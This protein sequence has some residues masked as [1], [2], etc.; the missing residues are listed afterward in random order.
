MEDDQFKADLAEMI[1]QTD[2]KHDEFSKLD[3]A[4]KSAKKSWEAMVEQVL[5]MGRRS[6]EE[7]P[8]FDGKAEVNASFVPDGEVIDADYSLRQIAGPP[9]GTC[10]DEHLADA[11]QDESWRAIEV[12]ELVRH[13]L[14]DKL[15]TK[16]FDAGM[17]TMGSLANWSSSGKQLTDLPGI[18]DSKAAEI[19]EALASFWS[20]WRKR[21]A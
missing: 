15:I 8:L 9:P 3:K 7:H 10:L 12:S 20:G 14:S 17:S 5:A 6:T 11:R 19:D 16:L 4:A 13:G 1:G 18:G 21:S 2:A